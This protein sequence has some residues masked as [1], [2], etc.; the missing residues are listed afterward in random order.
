MQQVQSQSEQSNKY[1][2]YSLR[3]LLLEY[4]EYG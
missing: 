1:L 4:L 2:F 3:I